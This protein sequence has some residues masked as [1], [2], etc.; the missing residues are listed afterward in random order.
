MIT[1]TSQAAD[2]IRRATLIIWDEVP[3]QHKH[4]FE[5]VHRTLCDVRGFRCI[6]WWLAGNFRWRFCTDFCLWWKTELAP[7]LSM[8]ACNNLYY[9]PVYAS[10]FFS[11][12]MR[13]QGDGVDAEFSYWLSR[14]SYDPAM[15]GLIS[16]PEYIFDKFLYWPICT[17]VSFPHAEIANCSLQ[18]G[19]F[20]FPRHS[21][22]HSMKC[23]PRWTRSY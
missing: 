23:L 2:L 20:S 9:G 16:L 17:S 6:I 15:N 10:W 14:L 18:S 4:C 22:P 1:E 13:L 19:V 12:N 3:M 8:L 11:K 7:A 21:L 5:A